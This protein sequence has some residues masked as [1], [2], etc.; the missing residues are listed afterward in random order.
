MN[1]STWATRTL[2]RRLQNLA[3]GGLRVVFPDG[4]TATYGPQAN[5]DGSA[6]LVEM[7]I[8]SWRFLPRVALGG[9]L[10]FAE[11]YMR[12]EWTADDLTRLI[13]LFADN[14][15]AMGD[16]SAQAAWPRRI[17]ERV[18]HWSR[19]NTA[20][21]N[22]RNIE[23]HYDLGNDFFALFLDPSMT[24]SCGIFASPDDSLE[25][26][27]RRK[28]ATVLE[29]AQLSREHHLLEIGSGWGSFALTAAREV[30]CRVTTLTQSQ[31]QLEHVQALARDAGLDHLVDVQL[32]DYRSARG[33]Y[34]RIVSIEMLEAVGHENLPTY[35]EVCG[36]LL[37]PGGR[38]VVQVITIEDHLY[39]SYRKG[40]DFIRRY[41]F[42]GGHLPSLGAL[43]SA[44][45][46]TADLRIEAVEDIGPHYAPTLARWRERF[47]RSTDR[48]D[49]MGFDRRF[50]R[51]WE[52]Y[53]A[54]CEAGFR[55][56]MLGDLHLVLTHGPSESVASTA[57]SAA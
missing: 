20:R 12:G 6:D 52:Y 4:S 45:T 9:D 18:L 5:G 8:H 2:G 30:G 21:G 35:F 38:A 3:T 42:P 26:A 48:L 57:R 13:K 24:Y 7:R 22:R 40:S 51:T 19:R 25:Q 11:S 34:D 14:R 10:G 29:K 15:D 56:Q 50:V 49:A 53:F 54:Y 16:A 43:R 32:C 28:I 37:Q 17:A 31:R 36:R 44:I 47:L 33:T 39:D 46:K 23:A 1:L 55:G 27:Q 41:I